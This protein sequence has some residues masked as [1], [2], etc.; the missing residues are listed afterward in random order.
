MIESKP[1]GRT[2]TIAETGGF[3]ARF[4]RS[5]RGQR[6]AV[7]TRYLLNS[8]FARR[9]GDTSAKTEVAAEYADKLQSPEFGR[10][11]MTE[12]DVAEANRDFQRN[13]Q[14]ALLSLL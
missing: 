4:R 14:A 7:Q 11:V 2:E 3:R 13:S 12:A 5:R 8:I 9:T 1:A 6:P 10:L